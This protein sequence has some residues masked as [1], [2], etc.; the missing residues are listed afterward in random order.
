[1]T[2]ARSERAFEAARRVLPGGVDSPVRAFGAVGGTPRFIARAEGAWLEDVDGNRLLD[3]VGSWGPMILGHGHPDVRRAI[4][5][6]VAR[7]WSY[8]APTEAETELAEAVVAAVPSLERVRFV[9]SGT[10]ATMSAIRLARAATGRRAVVKFAGCY[11][12]HHDALLVQAGSGAATTGTPSSPGVPP[13]CTADT[14]V[15]RY[16]DLASVEHAFDAR[17]GD[18]AAVIVEP[19]AGNMGVVAP[20]PGFLDGLRQLCSARGA[21]LIFDEV[22][23]GLRLARGGAQERFGITPDLTTL[24]KVIGGGMP[25]GAY[26]G[27][28]DLMARISPEGDV[29]QAGTLSGNPVAMAA[30][31]ATLAV[32]ERLDGWSRLERLGAR[33]EAALAPRLEP[34]ADRV[35]LARVGSMFT[36][37]FSARP[38]EDFDAALACDT[39]AFGRYFHAMLEAGIHLPPSQFEANFISLAHTEDDI[40]R[41]AAAMADAVAH[42]LSDA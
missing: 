8:G 31:R 12:G 39:G 10:E 1:M 14:L 38:V 20:R 28:A 7:G 5:E 32:L 37:F 22:M 34:Y 17:P 6:A 30:G 36:L 26:G 42:A 41:T 27:R 21:L 9:N 23:T 18:V 15:C 29:Y 35:R 11:H 13:G 2:T 19:V 4:A 16:N 33:L 25:V 3:Y 40:D 24:G